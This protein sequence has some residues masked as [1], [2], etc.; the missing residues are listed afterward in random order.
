MLEFVVWI[1]LIN[2]NKKRKRKSWMHNLTTYGPVSH[3]C[4]MLGMQ[5]ILLAKMK[6]QEVQPAK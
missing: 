5:F 3:R 6:L 4:Y 1:L 2:P